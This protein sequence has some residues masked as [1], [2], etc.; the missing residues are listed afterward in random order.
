MLKPNVTDVFQLLIEAASSVGLVV[1]RGVDI[2]YF[3]GVCEARYTN[4]D[5]LNYIIKC[6]F[7]VML[8]LDEEMD[9][10]STLEMAI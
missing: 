1:I 10:C 7:V 9:L 5:T 8:L 2:E 4:R 3:L 6:G